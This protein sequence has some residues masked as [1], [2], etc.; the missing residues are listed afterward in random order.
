MVEKAVTVG[1]LAGA[2]RE[3]VTFRDEHEYLPIVTLCRVA[4]QSSRRPFRPHP[5][6][7]YALTPTM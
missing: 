3:E 5:R 4:R 7:Q 1:D 2:D 6:P